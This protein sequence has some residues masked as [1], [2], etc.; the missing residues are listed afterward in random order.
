MLILN[1]DP[2][3]IVE[4]TRSCGARLFSGTV[5]KKEYFGYQYY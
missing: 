5:S 4:V 3:L 2:G 1:T